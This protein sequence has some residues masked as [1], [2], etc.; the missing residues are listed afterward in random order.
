MMA[1]GGMRYANQQAAKH[2]AEQFMGALANADVEQ[3]CRHSTREMSGNFRR[4]TTEKQWSADPEVTHKVESVSV[5]S[6]EATVVIHST[7]SGFRLQTTKL[8]LIRV[9]EDWLVKSGSF[10]IGQR[11][12]K[13][14]KAE[15]EQ[16]ADRLFLDLKEAVE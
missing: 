6:D 4:L 11:W 16:Q 10:R 15:Q 7:K 9:H 2:A 13:H 5:S 8:L 14:L 12:A 3:M 1:F